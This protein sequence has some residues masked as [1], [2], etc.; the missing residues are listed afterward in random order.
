MASS[1]QQSIRYLQ[2]RCGTHLL[3]SH[4]SVLEVFA[5][6]IH[7]MRSN[8]SIALLRERNSSL[9]RK[10]NI[11]KKTI[12]T[13]LKMH[14]ISAF[15]KSK[16]MCNIVDDH[17]VESLG[18]AEIPGTAGNKSSA[19]LDQIFGILDAMDN[20]V[21][22]VL[23]ERHGSAGDAL[24]SLCDENVAAASPFGRVAVVVHGTGKDTLDVIQ[25]HHTT[26]ID[27]NS[28]PEVVRFLEGT[29]SKRV[30]K[31][32]KQK[33]VTTIWSAGLLKMSSCR[34]GISVILR[35]CLLIRVQSCQGVCVQVW[36]ARSC[37][38]S[39]FSWLRAG[40]TSRS[41]VWVFSL[42]SLY[43]RTC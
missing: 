21:W 18:Q 34:S 39:I 40:R 36:T 10:G 6:L 23:V 9:L 24:R 32:I 1:D 8:D 27:V 5:V 28:W 15:I 35:V 42:L 30:L 4:Q 31:I 7:G 19:T 17:V 20:N 2:E 41:E 29:I 25:K 14:I 12:T 33:C 3:S 22:H 38:W 26:W 43:K 13:V 16:G 11:W 37:V